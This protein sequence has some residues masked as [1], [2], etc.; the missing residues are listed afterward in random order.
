MD[1]RGGRLLYLVGASGAGK[2][3]LLDY[4]R[5]SLGAHAGVRFAR[6][7]ITRPACSGGEDHIALGRETFLQLQAQGQFAMTWH[8]HGLDYGI[9]REVLDWLA[10]GLCVV[11]NGSRDYLPVAAARFGVLEP[12]LVQVET[13]VLR[14]R[15]R[16]RGRETAD[17]IERRLALGAQRDTAL[18]HPQLLLLDN[19]G[20]LEAAGERLVAIILGDPP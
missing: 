19:N 7:C 14:A 17:D 8:S 13:G 5:H 9:G 1:G 2:D 20:P 6:R 10:Q 15:L 18:H 12:V 16:A 3:S 11:V 4:A